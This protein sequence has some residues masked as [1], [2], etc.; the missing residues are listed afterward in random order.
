MKKI[1]TCRAAEEVYLPFLGFGRV[2]GFKVWGG[3][4]W[5][6]G[7]YRVLGSGCGGLGFTFLGL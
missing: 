4:S 7:F 2:L 5:G 3:G 6:I 1:S